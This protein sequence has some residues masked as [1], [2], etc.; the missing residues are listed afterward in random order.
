MSKIALI[1]D[2]HLNLGYPNNIKHWQEVHQT[3]FNKFLIPELKSKLSAN[4]KIIQLGNF[5]DNSNI[6]PITILNYAQHIL[7]KLSQICEVHIIIG[8]RDLYSKSSNKINALSLFKHIPNVIIHTE[9]TELTLFNKSV[10]MMPWVNKL[11]TQITLLDKYK[12]K[13]YLFCHSDLAEA[14]P[15][16]SKNL[17]KSKDKISIANF[18]GYNQIFSGHLHIS[19]QID[20]FKFVGNIFQM[21]S[22][23]HQNDKGILI[24]D[25]ITNTVVSILNNISPKF[26][27]ILI[28]NEDDIDKLSQITK[29]D[30]NEVI[31]SQN[32]IKNRKI[33]RILDPIL[34]TNNFT[35]VEYVDDIPKPEVAPPDSVELVNI[36]ETNLDI[37][38][39]IT[40]YVSQQKYDD[41]TKNGILNELNAII[42][43]H[44]S[45]SIK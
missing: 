33:R 7:E 22:G 8:N 24:L 30:Y 42:K 23:D 43:I 31:I 45:K 26:N 9:T 14:I 41:D 32:L 11:E 16:S 20:N 1:G 39:I 2:I 36:V 6:L 44:T 19:Q 12:G 5:F 25:T 38:T 34:E 15:D 21:H 35:S 17:N 27:K 37:N 18:V 10:L 40:N 3:Y 4:D 13:N 28:N 29:S